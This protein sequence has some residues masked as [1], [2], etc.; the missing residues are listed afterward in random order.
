[1]SE[2]I[3][4]AHI[5]LSDDASLVVGAGASA[6]D[7]DGLDVEFMFHCLRFRLRVEKIGE[8][9]RVRS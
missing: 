8:E 5:L 4:T 9:N 6:S 1:M 2:I 3:Y 7:L